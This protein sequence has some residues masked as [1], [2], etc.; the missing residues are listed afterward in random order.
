M[1]RVTLVHGNF[2]DL[3]AVMDKLELSG[4]DGMLFDLGGVLPA[5]GR[6]QP[7]LFLHAGRPAGYADGSVRPLTAYDVVN[8]WP[9]E[10]LRRILFRYGEEKCST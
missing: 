4:A 2:R 9:R 5:V 1:D 6:R 3:A 8:T 10:E 7:G